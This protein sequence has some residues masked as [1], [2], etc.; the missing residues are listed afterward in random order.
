MFRDEMTGHI[1]T[2]LK[3]FSRKE[4]RLF[5]KVWQKVDK[6][7]VWVHMESLEATLQ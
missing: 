7:G 5:L 3:Y 2:W 4:Y 1:K 6:T